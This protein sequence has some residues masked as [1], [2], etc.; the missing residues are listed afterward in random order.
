MTRATTARKMKMTDPIRITLE[1]SPGAIA[2]LLRQIAAAEPLG[3]PHVLQPPAGSIPVDRLL[4]TLLP[5][6]EIA[7]PPD[8]PAPET[9]AAESFWGESVPTSDVKLLDIERGAREVRE[10]EIRQTGGVAF[11][12]L[13]S[14]WSNGFGIPAAPQPDR[15]KLLEATMESEGGKILGFLRAVG[16]LT[17]AVMEV[18]PNL[19]HRDTRLLAENIASVSS[20]V[21]WSDLA[22]TLEYERKYR[23]I[24]EVK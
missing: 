22:D 12:Y 4:R 21:G 17:Q 15:V 13:V 14:N 10:A 1:G 11:Y 5:K 24:G 20:A 7:A 3:S 19:S 8:L 16:G 9:E 6:Q 2:D 23:E 18:M